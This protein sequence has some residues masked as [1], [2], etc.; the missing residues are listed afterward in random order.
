[1]AFNY[2]N[3]SLKESINVN[4]ILFFLSFI[5]FICWSSTS[6]AQ[7][8]EEHL[9]VP[10]VSTK[11]EVVDAMLK[12]AKVNK[13]DLIYDL[14]CGDGRIVIMAAKEYG[15]KGVGVDIDPLRI[16]EANENAIKEGV[17]DH[18]TFIEQDLFEVDFSE[19]TVVT[20]YLLPYVNL[21]LRPLLLEKLKPGT[22]IVSN[23][24]DMG[25]WKPEKQ[26]TVGES[27]IYFWTVPEKA[28]NN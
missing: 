16:K 24:F 21:K 8:I 2:L 26:I 4:K 13:D 10:Y 1:M 7:E 17:T 22:R 27:T 20:L 3:A 19:A 25:D 15:A 9:D 5:L 28:A 11:P 12:I 18:V 14:G 6:V 23:E